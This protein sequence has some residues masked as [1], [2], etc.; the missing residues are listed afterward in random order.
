MKKKENTTKRQHYV[1]QVLIKN[2]YNNSNRVNAYLLKDGTI[3][4][5]TSRDI[6]HKKYLY[7]YDKDN[8]L[9]EIEKE[10]NPIEGKLGDSFRN[11]FKQLNNI[12]IKNSEG[13][14]VPINEDIKFICRYLIIQLLRT[15]IL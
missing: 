2:F 15:L 12:D 1:P 13:C 14:L 9:N 10:F 7:E 4:S 8:H 6:C 5:S 11:I 3:F